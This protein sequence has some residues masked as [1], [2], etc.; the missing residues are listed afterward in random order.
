MA[1]VAPERIRVEVAYVEPGRQ[2][3]RAV[4]VAA[5]ATVAEAIAASGVGAAFPHLDVANGK[6]GIF[7]RPAT[8][9]RV[10]RDGDRVE[11]YRP[12]IVDPKAA[13]RRRAEKP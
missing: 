6:V 11:I 9:D 10:L 1:D 3:L 7:S 5:G 2:F 12:L 4:D 13:R 8:H